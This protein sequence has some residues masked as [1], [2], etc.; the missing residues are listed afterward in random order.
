MAARVPT[1]KTALMAVKRVSA[2]NQQIRTL[3]IAIMVQRAVRRRRSTPCVLL[4]MQHVSLVAV[5]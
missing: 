5:A 3:V 2:Q 4:L 1:R